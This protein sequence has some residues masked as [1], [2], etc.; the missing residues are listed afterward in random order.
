ML[1]FFV[2]EPRES[3]DRVVIAEE[4]RLRVLH[5]HREDVLFDEPEEIQVRVAGDVIENELLFRVAGGEEERAL[6]IC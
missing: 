6:K 1:H 4:L 3:A 2:G 5:G